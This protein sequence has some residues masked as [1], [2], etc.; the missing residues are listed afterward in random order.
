MVI[1]TGLLGFSFI[2]KLKTMGAIKS[3]NEVTRDATI[4]I[5]WENICWIKSNGLKAKLVDEVDVTFS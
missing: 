2:A 3:I 1:C 4:A 5:A